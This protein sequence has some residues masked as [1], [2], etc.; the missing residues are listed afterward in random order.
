MRSVERH[1]WR[2]KFGQGML[3]VSVFIALS[4][5]LS[6]TA[7]AATAPPSPPGSGHGRSSQG[8]IAAKS[9]S[10]THATV[11]H[12]AAAALPDAT[13]ALST[14][15]SVTV[16]GGYT[17][18]GI[19]MRN[20]GYGTISI[21]GVPAGATVTSATLL[22]DVLAD[23]SDPTFAQ[24]TVNGTS[25]NGTLW[26][27]GGSPCWPPGSNW[28]YEADVTNLV[29][30]NGSYALAGFASG[31]SDGA[32][33]WNAGSAPPLLEGASLVVV[34]TLASMPKTTIQIGEGA[35]ETDSGNTATA[36]LGGFTAGASPVATTT[37]IVAD[38]QYGD[39]AATFNGTTLPG[40]TFPG[41][42]PQAVPNYSLGNL[43]DTTTTDVSSLVNP[44]DTSAT[45][46]VT[47][48]NDCLVWV[49]QVLAVTSPSSGSQAY[50]AL[51]DSYS[52][53]EGDGGYLAGT[54]T[55]TDHCHRSTHAY[56]E[57]LDQNQGLG[58]LDFVS[59]SGAITDDYFNP[60]NESNNEPA[61]SQA[62]SSSTKYVTLT[63]GGNDLGFSDV[64]AKCVYGKVGPVVVQAANC[65]K[66]SPLQTTV[67][68]RLQALAGKATAY[69]PQGVKIHSIASVLQ[70]IHQ[71]APN[72]KIYVADYP[73]LFGTH[74]RSDCGVGKVLATHTPIG[75]VTVAL[76][77]N[78][79][80]T[81]WLN[82]VGTS[83]ANVI[84]TA[85]A[86]NGATFVD[87]SPKFK[88]H[89]FCDTSNSWFNYVSGT[90]NDKTKQK[91]IWV[92]S[93]HPTPTGQK[94][95]YEA[96]F[97]TAGL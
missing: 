34:Y 67:A 71:L 87:A 47:G 36:T 64:L 9:N 25:I 8:T 60:N 49:G 44:G 15:S 85:A 5:V 12:A 56:P 29:K 95:G 4:T 53:G 38:G 18:A 66:D 10:G 68:K 52:S 16:N 54:S 55:S 32:D 90:Y 65:A 17:A 86:A 43:W 75:N 62:L 59:C 19:G 21:T 42:D 14:V 70:S 69:T 24:G 2:H 11:K 1:A 40:V 13:G 92:G 51:G 30:G 93:F 39:S 74:F 41:A 48:T 96:A 84:K 50:V 6:G 31:E 23:S 82:S 72:A 97:S 61:Q 73:L 76:K 57:L 91:N 7:V 20:L 37:Y 45:L 89:R 83:L 35:T 81:T 77:L 63:F 58:S 33:P 27:S 26:A 79:A 46:S 28:S 3:A 22:W 80:E 88:S 94:S 78:K